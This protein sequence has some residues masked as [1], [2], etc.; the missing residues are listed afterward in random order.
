MER[1]PETR[2]RPGWRAEEVRGDPLSIARQQLTPVER[3]TEVGWRGITLAWRRP[4]RIEVRQ[5]DSTHRLPIHDQTWRTI[6]IVVVAELV[7]GAVGL[8]MWRGA[9]RRSRK[10]AA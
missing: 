9:S 4:V 8:Q 10:R 3:V 2:S 5:D 7:L 1:L 6:A